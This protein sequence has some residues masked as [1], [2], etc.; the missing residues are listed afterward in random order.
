MDRQVDGIKPM[1]LD[2]LVG[3]EPVASSAHRPDRF[4]P[5]IKLDRKLW[6]RRVASP[7]PGGAC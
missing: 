4:H 5:E 7:P 3:C 2:L 1:H 6:R